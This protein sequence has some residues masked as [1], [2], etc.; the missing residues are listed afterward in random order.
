[1]AEK[2]STLIIEANLECEK[3]YR[4]IQK[5][6]CKLQ[7]KEKIR[8]INFDTK[9]NTVTVSGPFDPVKLSKKLRCK[10]CKAIKDIKI[11]EEKK[12]DA[13]KP[14]E[15]KP[16]E[17]KPEEKKPAADGC[18]SIVTTRKARPMSDG[19]KKAARARSRSKA[20]W[21]F[22]LHLEKV[23]Q[24]LGMMEAAT[25]AQRAAKE[26]TQ[27]F[28]KQNKINNPLSQWYKFKE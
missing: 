25:P 23:A 11:I 9:K 4:K 1:M 7:E 22:G 14:E 3:C 17:K 8:T 10:A 27:A 24:L 5:V 15:K 18:N 6:L 21:G 19:A 16:E 2:V 20:H 13:K 26:S 12:P 28:C